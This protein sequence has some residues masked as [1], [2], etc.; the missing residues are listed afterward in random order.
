MHYEIEQA[1]PRARTRRRHPRRAGALA[2]GQRLQR[3]RPADAAA[4]RH[5]RAGPNLHHPDPGD[6]ADRA[7]DGR[8][9]ARAGGHGNAMRH[10]A[11]APSHYEVELRQPAPGDGRT[12]ATWRA[13]RRVGP[14]GAMQ[15]LKFAT[16]QAA[17]A[18]V[19]RLRPKEARVVAVEHSGWCWTVDDAKT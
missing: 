19:E 11:Q 7:D 14:D 16:L 9:R 5:T 4:V 15:P 8:G 10:I 12:G 2:R 6:A 13:V 17:Q 3:R 18:H 1:G